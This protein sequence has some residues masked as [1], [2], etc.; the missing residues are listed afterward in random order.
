MRKKI[1]MKSSNEAIAR[2]EWKK[3]QDKLKKGVMDEEL[4]QLR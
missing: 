2:E 4:K 1:L 3:R